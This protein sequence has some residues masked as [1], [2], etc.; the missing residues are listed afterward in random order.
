[1]TFAYCLVS[2]IH[3][4]IQNLFLSHFLLVF[5]RKPN[6]SPPLHNEEQERN[7][8]TCSVISSKVSPINACSL[9]HS[10]SA[11]SYAHNLTS[12]IFTTVNVILRIS[13]PWMLLNASLC[14][15]NE[16]DCVL[17]TES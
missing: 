15:R 5:I 8:L 16:C 9:V 12:V 3:S 17:E 11:N 4:V 1:M 14:P 2:S 7:V 10:S 13:M 6:P